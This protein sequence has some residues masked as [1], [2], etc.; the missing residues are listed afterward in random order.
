MSTAARP[1]GG[2]EDLTDPT[3]PTRPTRPARPARSTVRVLLDWRD[4][5]AEA[6]AEACVLCGQPTW[7]WSPRGVPCH[8]TCAEVWIGTRRPSSDPP[9]GDGPAA[10]DPTT[11]TRAD[12]GPSGGRS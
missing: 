2:P 9:A 7:C 3:R 8:K 5:S 12:A 1:T 6:L 10:G 11:D 4:G